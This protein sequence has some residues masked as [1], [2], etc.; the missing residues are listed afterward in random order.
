MIFCNCDHGGQITPT[1]SILGY[2]ILCL[3]YRSLQKICQ[4]YNRLLTSGVHH[5][6]PVIISHIIIGLSTHWFDC[7]CMKLNVL[8]R[9][10]SQR[11]VPMYTKSRTKGNFDGLCRNVSAT[12]SVMTCHCD[13]Y[14]KRITPI[15]ILFWASDK[16]EILI[17]NL[18]GH[19]WSI[20][21]G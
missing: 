11:K 3:F 7:C 1:K 9:T 19:W 10:Q 6:T 18:N 4:W 21:R 15:G 13:V 5:F 20:C 17:I 12:N 2:F 16:W 8:W 14:K